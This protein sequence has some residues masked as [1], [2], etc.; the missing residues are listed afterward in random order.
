[1]RWLCC[2]VL[3]MI[4]LE[5]N[6]LLAEVAAAEWRNAVPHTFD[7]Q[8][9]ISLAVVRGV[10]ADTMPGSGLVHEWRAMGVRWSSSTAPAAGRDAGALCHPAP[11]QLWSRR[12]RA[13]PGPMMPTATPAP[14]PAGA[15]RLLD[16]AGGEESRQVA[17]Y[18]AVGVWNAVFGIA[19]FA[20]LTT[21]SGSWMPYLVALLITYVVTVVVAFALYRA[22]V[23]RFG[24]LSSSASHV[25]RAC[26]F[27]RC[28]A[29][30]FLLTVL[31]EVFDVSVILRPGG[32]VGAR[33]RDD[34]RRE[35]ALHPH[36]GPPTEDARACAVRSR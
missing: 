13:D 6:V 11:A 31:V 14:R 19:L 18:V 26:T 25:S 27:P 16:R 29:T 5:G 30:L 20:G 34:L 24:Y 7:T 17:R 12:V 36:P 21:D 8:E 28:P 1:M 35:P 10:S 4:S 2:R 32:R 15:V 22:F 9:L 33:D 3:A 23:F